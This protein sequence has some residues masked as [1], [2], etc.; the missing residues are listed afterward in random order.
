MHCLFRDANQYPSAPLASPPIEVFQNPG[1]TIF[2]PS[3]WH[4]QVWNLVSNIEGRN[5]YCH[6]LY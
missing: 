6:F 4:H 1:E 5:D 3:G 2:V